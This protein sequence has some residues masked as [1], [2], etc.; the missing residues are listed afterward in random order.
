MRKGRREVLVFL[1][2]SMIGTSGLAVRSDSG[3]T[4]ASERVALTVEVELEHPIRGRRPR[5]TGRPN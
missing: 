5:P 2:T 4:P 1:V 3:Q